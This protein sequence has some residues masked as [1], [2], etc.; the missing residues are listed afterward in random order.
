MTRMSSRGLRFPQVVQPWA[1][2]LVLMSPTMVPEVLGAAGGTLVLTVT[3]RQTGKPTPFRIHLI[4]QF[5]R[6]RKLPGGPY[7]VDH[8]TAA[9]QLSMRL[10]RGAYA[11]EIECGPEYAYRFGNFVIN[12]NSRGNKT[13]DM[14]RVVD[15]TEH[16]WY[17]ADLDL[18]RPASEMQLLLSAEGLHF[19]PLI[20]GVPRRTWG[21]PKTAKPAGEAN[22]EGLVRFPDGRCYTLFG[23]QGTAGENTLTVFQLKEPPKLPAAAQGRR[24]QPDASALP[25]LVAALQQ[26]KAQGAW[27][28]LTKATWDDLPLWVG[29]GL[30]DSVG[31]AH[32]DFGRRGPTHQGQPAGRIPQ[33]ERRYRGPHGEG[34]WTHEVY[35]QLLNAGVHI[36]PSAGSGSGVVSNP[37]GYNR[38]YVYVDPQDLQEQGLSGL[39]AQ[40]WWSGL[41]AGRCFVTNGPLLRPRC[42]N[43]V[44]GYIFSANAG[45][46]T[47]FEI[48]TTLYTRDKI[49]YLEV[50]QDGKTV[51]SLR[52]DEYARRGG[53]LPQ[54]TFQQS[55][56]FLLRA[57]CTEAKT[58]RFAMTAPWHVSYN[59]QLRVSRSAVAFFEQWLEERTKTVLAELEGEAR[60]TMSKHFQQAQEFWASQAEAANA[61]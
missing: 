6:P 3:D 12:E 13:V 25:N 5:K 47:T 11:F 9:G 59:G 14:K 43:E 17:S 35:F 32:R 2:L 18:Q 50:V 48:E 8:T 7:W 46:S 26:A 36:P 55:G 58:Y 34:R 4:N 29:L 30:V 45:E 54:V 15:M 39:Q 56:W 27:I 41:R 52:L 20:H 40:D 16:H 19:T 51:Y 31:V 38:V 1:L 21:R 28:D 61:P 57:V 22:E 33:Q 37:A 24:S 53:K 10:P 49:D 23:R 42:R 44:P 60:E